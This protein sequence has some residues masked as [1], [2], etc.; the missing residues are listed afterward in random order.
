MSC[1]GNFEILS[2]NPKPL[3]IAV[4]G[5]SPNH[6]VFFMSKYD[7]EG[8]VEESATEGSFSFDVEEEGDYTM[9]MVNGERRNNDG[10]SRLV[11]FNLRTINN[12]NN[13]YETAVLDSELREFQHGN[14]TR[15]AQHLK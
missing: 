6:T 13:D 15:Q 8:A 9:C 4:T 3:T 1:Y 14:K 7:G 12:G 11:A 10:I 2:P 5:P